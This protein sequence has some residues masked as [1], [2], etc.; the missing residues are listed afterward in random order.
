MVG[1]LSL[2]R[3]CRF[4]CC[5]VF[6]EALY[7]VHSAIGTEVALRLGTSLIP[8]WRCAVFWPGALDA[9]IT[10]YQQQQHSALIN[11][12]LTFPASLYRVRHCLRWQLAV[13]AVGSNNS[14]ST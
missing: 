8:V 12:I 11:N 9:T 13:D 7:S 14:Q 3:K 6:T 5:T 2:L 10:G 1:K 4:R